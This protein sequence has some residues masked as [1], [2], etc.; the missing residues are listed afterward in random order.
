MNSKIQLLLFFTLLTHNCGKYPSGNISDPRVILIS[1]DGLNGDMMES[2]FFRDSCPN[3]YHLMQSGTYCSNVQSVFPSLTYPAHTSMVSGK[4][5]EKHGI[6]NNKLFLPE[7]N[8]SDWYW[9]EDSIKTETI[10]TKANKKGLIS[11]GVGWPVTVGSDFDYLLPEI[12]SVNDT[13]STIDLVR[14]YDN[15]KMFLESAKIRGIIP[16]DGN[17]EGYHRDLL[18]HEV[19]LDAFSNKLPH[20]SLYHMIETD[21]AQHNH[22]KNSIEAKKAFMFMDS[23]IGNIT[24]LL[25]EKH[26]WDS[27]TII[28]SGDHGF[29]NYE[30]QLSINKFFED[31]GWLEIKDDKIINWKVSALASGGS[32][33]VR[34]KDPENETFRKKVRIALSK[35]EGFEILEPRHMES[36]FWTSKKTDFI[37]I[38]REKYV[39]VQSL[40]QPYKKDD[41]GGTHGGDPR[42]KSLKTG[43][44]AAGRGIKKGKIKALMITDIAY[45]IST[46]LDLEL[47]QN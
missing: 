35:Q 34:L 40:G 45:Q 19:F 20:L 47:D 14:K 24:N 15:P 4:L 7:K 23:L 37:L 16:E 5:P 28:I 6:L 38:A 39:F 12:Q 27:T 32:A 41:F 30:T 1:I 42:K 31:C 43:Y 29:R 46:L 33:F 25:K 36:I 17:P 22:G 44:I 18:I 3:L 8:F 21:L 10:I 11:L 9:F 13:I 26:L 2:Y